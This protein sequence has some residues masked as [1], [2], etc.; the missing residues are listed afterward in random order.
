MDYYCD[1]CDK[2]IKL[3]SETKHLQSLTHNKID[4]CVRVKHRKIVISLT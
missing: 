4:Q 2:T 1:V 3:K